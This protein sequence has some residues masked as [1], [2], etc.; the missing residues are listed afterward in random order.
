MNL[1]VLLCLQ[2]EWYTVLGWNGTPPGLKMDPRRSKDEA[3]DNF[4]VWR[5]AWTAKTVY[6]LRGLT[7]WRI[8]HKLI[9]WCCCA[10]RW[11]GTLSSIHVRKQPPGQ[12]C[13][14]TDFTLQLRV[15]TVKFTV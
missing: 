10:S 6:W 3:T 4:A 9:R 15:I 8:A 12:G 11:N 7:F 14:V 13:A 5:L 1:V 2:V